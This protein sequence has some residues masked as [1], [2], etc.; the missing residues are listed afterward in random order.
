MRRF[1]IAL[2]SAAAV[3]SVAAVA[4]P[5]VISEESI[6]DAAVRMVVAMTGRVP[7]IGGHAILTLSDSVIKEN[8][9]HMDHSR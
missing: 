6:K 8:P 7:T 2:A 1:A 3:L 4:L 5:W 9:G